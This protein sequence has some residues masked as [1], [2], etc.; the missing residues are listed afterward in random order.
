LKVAVTG[1]TGLIG[2]GVVRALRERG[3]EVTALSRDGERA[4]AQLGVPATSWDPLAGPAPAE[5]LAG[6]DGVVNLLGAPV[7]KRWSEAVRTEIMESRRTGT[8]NLVAGLRAAEPRPRVLVSGSA[9]GYYGARGE[10]PIDEEAS[11][12]SGFL[13]DVAVAW[14]AAATQA[15][16]LGVRVVTVRTGLVLARD[17]GALA[18]MLPVFKLGLGGQFANGRQYMPWIHV[19]DEVGVILA[20][21]DGADWEGPINA[22]AP[23]PVTNREF[24]KALGRALHRPAVLPV[25][26]FAVRAAMGS[27]AEIV[28]TGVRMVPARALVLGYRFR[29][30]QLDEALAAALV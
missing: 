8:A 11:A 20:A 28:T 30:P 13:A 27:A 3:D 18:K 15:R 9:S 12:G 26:G 10:E 23:E 17:G 24:I 6:S 19:D 5:A 25:P 2:G 1:A 29:Y 21:L 22:S 4:S 14:E 7:S 16:E